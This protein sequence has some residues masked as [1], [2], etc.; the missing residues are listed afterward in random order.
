MTSETK[1]LCVAEKPSVAKEIS[2]ILSGNCFVMRNSRIAYI[3]NYEFKCQ[4][5]SKEVQVIMT[6]VC[7]HINA[8]DFPY[9]Y[10]KWESC[11]PAVLFDAPIVKKIIDNENAESIRDNIFNIAHSVTHL[12]IWTDCDR[13]GEKIGSDIKDICVMANAGITVSRARFSA[14]IPTQI[15][16]AWESPALLDINQA[17][18]VSARMELDLRIGYAFT[19]Y[20]TLGFK[21]IFPELGREKVLSY[22][23]CQFPTL[24]FVVEK[25]KAVENFI[26]ESFW[27]IHVKAERD[28]IT[29][30]FNWEKDKLFNVN[31]CNAIYRDLIMEEPIIAH[32]IQVGTKETKKYKPYPLTTVELQKAGCRFLHISSDEIMKIAE[33][34]YNKGFISYPR[35]ETDQF[36]DHNFNFQELIQAQT[37]DQRWGDFASNLVDKRITTK[38]GRH[39]DQAH[40]P[41]HPVQ[42]ASGLSGKERTVYEFVVRRFLACC[43]EDAKGNETTVKIRIK[44]EY[45]TAKGL[46]IS[47]YN[48][49]DVYPYDRW[50]DKN[51]PNFVLHETFTPKECTMEE[52]ETSPPEYLTEAELINIMDKNGIGTDATIHEHIKKIID[53]EYV[54]KQ[55]HGNKTYL[56]PTNLGLALVEG[57]DSIDLN[58]SL[59][60]PLLRAKMEQN[61][62]QICESTR[63]KSDVLTETINKYRDMF[64]MTH[65]NLQRLVEGFAKYF[66]LNSES[67]D[68]HRIFNNIVNVENPKVVRWCRESQVS[69]PMYLKNIQSNWIISCI[70][71]PNCSHGFFFNN[72]SSIKS[73]T[74]NSEICTI[75]SGND[76]PIHYLTV[77]LRSNRINRGCF[78]GCDDNMDMLLSKSSGTSNR[79]NDGGSRRGSRS[80]RGTNGE[81]AVRGG[82]R[83]TRG[84]RATRRGGYNGGRS[85]NLDRMES[86]LD[87]TQEFDVDKL[88]DVVRAFYTGVGEEQKRAQTVLTQFQNHQDAWLKVDTILEK[89]KFTH[90]K[91]IALQILEKLIQQKWKILPPEQQAGIRSFIVNIIVA[92]S[93]NE[94]TLRREKTYLSKLNL[95]L[96][97]ILKQEWPHNWPQFIPEIVSTG[98]SNVTICENN[99]AILKLLSE[100]IFDYS[101][102]Q[103]TQLKTK[104]LKTQMCHEFSKIFELCNEVL[105]KAHQPSLIKATLETLLKFLNWIPLGYIFETNIIENLRTRFLESPEYRNVT[106]KCL[107]E[108]GALNVSHEYDDK[109]IA[110]FNMVVTAL[111]TMVP[112]SADFSMIYKSSSNEEQE[113]IQNLALFFTGFLSFHL[114]IMESQQNNQPLLKAHYYLLRI[115]QVEEREVFKVCLEYWTKLVAEL[116]EEIQQLPVLDMP[117]LSLAGVSSPPSTLANIPLRKHMYNE[118]LTTLRVIM[119][120]RMVKPEEVLVVEND[121]GE[122]VREFMKDSDTITLYKSMRECLV[123]LTHLDV[124]DSEIIMSNKLTKQIDGS[125]WS[126]NNLNKLCWAIGSISGAMNEDTE[127]RFLVTVIKELLSLCEQKRG[128]DNKAV[129]ASNIMYIVGQYPRFLKAHWKFLKTVVNKLFEFMHETHEGVQDMACDT[130][131]KIAQKCRRQFISQQ[132]GENTPFID[133]IISGIET[134]TKDLSPQ[135]VQTFYEAVGYMISAQTNKNVQERLVMNYMELPNQ[136]W[137]RILEDISKDI[138][139]LHIAE[140]TKILGHVLR[141]NVAACNAVGSGFSVQ[142]ARIYVNLLELYKAV[143]R[144][145]SDTVATEGLIATKTPRVRNLRVIKKETL[146][147]MEVYI[148]KSEETSQIITHLMP[149]LLSAVLI[150]YNTNVEQARD[151]EVL[152][153]M[154]NIIAKLGP[155]ITNEVPAILN[156]VFECTLNMIN[157]DFSEY[158]EH[159]QFKLIMDSIVW[160]FKHTMRDIADTGLNICLELINNI[161]MQDPATANMF[162]QQYFLTLVAD[163]LFVLADTDHKS[164]IVLQRMFNL[165]ETGAVQSPLFNPTEVPDPNMTNQRFLRE[166]VMNILQNAFPHLQSV[167]VHSFVIGLFEL[168][169]DNTKFKLHLRDFLIQLKE[170]AGDN[171]DLYLEEREAEAEQRKKTEMENALKIPGLVKPSDLPM[172]DE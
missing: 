152:S 164:G 30:D 1:V 114:K 37:Q 150:D 120:D 53:R 9:Q 116:Y 39:N 98:R 40:P 103:M 64:T 141:T 143:S 162:Y 49:L 52:G 95:I 137:D 7:G 99:M 74:T 34:L 21:Q 146:K 110:L 147:L 101:A 171:A 20:Q 142:I 59:T 70:D 127:K 86:I 107:S 133:E 124:Q 6:S 55:F 83:G 25:Y 160:A 88:D 112:V 122:I 165:V 58:E 90:T 140:N 73:I 79:P 31:C 153:S 35:T 151:A 155:G 50:N 129:V 68:V 36:D 91:F 82:T 33:D 18:A 113:F 8:L 105:E 132:A 10:A 69:R 125:E 15:R 24:G 136:G 94:Q 12:M 76:S 27:K 138:N 75:C 43:S 130:F 41:I 66:T 172:E 11:S 67:N 81:E 118:I 93:D 84:S 119:I 4:L 128:K 23:S 163:V 92:T 26:R 104:N 51:L 28:N 159:P 56:I 115:S 145:I 42:Y 109:F 161:C 5:N 144:I 169:Q 121:E 54:E 134:I 47:D 57:Y 108:I 168:N 87:F 149:P 157:K 45:F 13:E 126:W 62:K 148:T 72:S 17:E 29:V 2:K 32:V 80:S 117:L 16:Q 44:D 3:K 14:I 85:N 139:A 100:E 46:V 89:S 38:K 60:K 158:P 71:F 19:R 106:L 167:Q 170:F 154:A 63:E 97:Q 156:A 131:I 123:Y 65:N 77:V 102:E 111:E 135:Q 48:Y 96:V 166:Y 78:G 22:G 61:L